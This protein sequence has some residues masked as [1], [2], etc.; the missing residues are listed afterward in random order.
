[1]S[2]HAQSYDVLHA[3]RQLLRRV[4]EHSRRLSRESGLTVP[5]LLCLKSLASQDG[6]TTVVE[7]G[8]AVDMSP[9]NVSGVLDRLE[10]SGLVERTRG[11]EDR[12]KVFVQLTKAGGARAQDLP[13][14]L[15]DGFVSRLTELD[16]TERR[17]IGE[18]LQKLIAMMDDPTPKPDAS[19]DAA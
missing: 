13:S 2:S 18:V 7:V 8:N 1:M 9:S 16:P 10:K 15:Q 11:T 14:P 6:P 3:I 19:A 12:R 17:H 4:S 5:Q